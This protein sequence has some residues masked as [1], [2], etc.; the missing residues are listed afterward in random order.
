MPVPDNL[1]RGLALESPRSHFDAASSP[2]AVLR[3][4]RR[5]TDPSAA[6]VGHFEAAIAGTAHVLGPCN[7][8]NYW[9]ASQSAARHPD[10]PD[11]MH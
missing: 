1:K 5:L 11:S 8:A 9:P 3:S 7:F 6:A 4:L 10:A 2:E